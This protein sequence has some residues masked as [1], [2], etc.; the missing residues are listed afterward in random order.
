ML[1]MFSRWINVAGANWRLRR[2]RGG[3]IADAGDGLAE[4]KYVENPGVTLFRNADQ[5]VTIWDSLINKLVA[6]LLLT[7]AISQT[8][9]PWRYQQVPVPG[10]V[11]GVD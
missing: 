2:Y 5:T 10:L 1:E 11:S 4:N 6:Y 7:H 9:P 3:F 8:P